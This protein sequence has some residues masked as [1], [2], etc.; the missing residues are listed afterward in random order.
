MY[1]DRIL[2]CDH[3][4]LDE[5]FPKS[6]CDSEGI[7]ATSR[8]D[9]RM[10]KIADT[11]RDIIGRPVWINN[12]L[13][14][15]DID[16]AGW[17]DPNTT[18]GASKSAHKQIWKGIGT[19]KGLLVSQALDFHVSQMSGQQLYNIVVAHAKTFFDLGV[20]QMEHYQITPGWC[21][22]AVRYTGIEG[23]EVI[24]KTNVAMI[25]KI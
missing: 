6:I 7:S 5:M 9:N 2:V 20:T 1:T 25:I 14:G 22:L 24:T 3:F 23:I 12:W 17:R 18:T 21:H 19:Q 10:F 4:Y 13:H 8:M 11:F 16:E 15:G